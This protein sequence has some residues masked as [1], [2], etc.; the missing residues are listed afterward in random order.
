MRKMI[1]LLVFTS[2]VAIGYS[3][4]IKV[5]GNSA[6]AKFLAKVKGEE[7]YAITFGRTIFVSCKK[8][9]FLAKEWWVNHEVAH[10]EQY[11]KYGILRF[12][13]LYAYYSVFHK[14]SGNRFEI[15][16]EIA[17]SISEEPGHSLT[18]K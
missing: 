1:L 18:S 14:K 13:A 11:E 5:V 7:S 9:D 16:A 12:F 15:E 8:K 4:K 17:E 6:I 10:V 3:Q 2:F